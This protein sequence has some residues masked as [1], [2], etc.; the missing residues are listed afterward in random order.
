MV[1]PIMRD[2]LFL[3]KKSEPATE[4]DKQVVVDLLDTLKANLDSC[5][6]MAANMIAFP[7]ICGMI[8]FYKYIDKHIDAATS[9]GGV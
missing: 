2:P 7:S 6:G 3:A 1:K 9:E 8:Y 5:V 4:T